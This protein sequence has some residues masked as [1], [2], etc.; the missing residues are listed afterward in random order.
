M[1]RSSVLSKQGSTRLTGFDY[2]LLCNIPDFPECYKVEKC[3]F[4]K[5]N[6][7]SAV[8]INVSR[9]SAFSKILVIKISNIIKLLLASVKY[10]ELL[11][12]FGSTLFNS[13]SNLDL[14][15]CVNLCGN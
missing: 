2:L 13:T 9:I 11:D 15:Y 5:K 10:L 7:G 1:G 8:N 14:F 6:R 4:Q 3:E 12:L